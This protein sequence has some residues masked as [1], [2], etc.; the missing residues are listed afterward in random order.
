MK[1]KILRLVIAGILVSL[2]MAMSAFSQTR[3][4]GNICFIGNSTSIGGRSFAIDINLTNTDTLAGFQIPFSFNY[5]GIGITCDSVSFLGGRCQH[6]DFLDNK[7]DSTSKVVYITGI[8]GVSIELDTPPLLPGS[9]KLATIYFSV[10]RTNINNQVGFT[11]TRFPDPKRDY[12]FFFWNLRAE[13]VEC[14]FSLSP[15]KLR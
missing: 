13:K 11:K 10:E 12:S 1:I 15:I 4:T 3:P 6:F 2:T 8:S 5:G 9:G 14:E 7:I